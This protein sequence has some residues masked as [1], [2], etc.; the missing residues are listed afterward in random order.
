MKINL[1]FESSVASPLNGL[2][3][4]RGLTLKVRFTARDVVRP[5]SD[6]NSDV[7]E[8]GSCWMLDIT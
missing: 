7:V 4:V 8:P 6:R 2:V 3:E 1:H 5:V